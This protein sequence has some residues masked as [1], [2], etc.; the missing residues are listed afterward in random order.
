MP[1]PVVR[2]IFAAMDTGAVVAM[3]H[4]QTA[5]R[6]RRSGRPTLLDDHARTI[7]LEAVRNGH[8]LANAARLAGVAPETLA[9]WLRRGRGQDVRPATP[10]Y[11]RLVAEVE[12]AQAEA[13]QRVLQVVIDAMPRDPRLAVW[14]LENAHPDWRR[15]RVLPEPE[16]VAPVAAPR[17]DVFILD[18]DTLRR[19]AQLKLAERDPD[20]RGSPLLGVGP[21]R[22][23]LVRDS[24][25]EAEDRAAAQEGRETLR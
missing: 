24:L 5:R 6:R 18:P 4:H 7:L 8:R 11:E 21:I 9:E 16:R 2:A 1:P 12:L 10:V 23:P 13:E 14:W 15:H 25:A 22:S 3:D 19:L 20:G 17:S